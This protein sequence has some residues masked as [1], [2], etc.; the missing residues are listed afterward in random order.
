MWKMSEQLEG[1]SLYSPA[2]TDAPIFLGAVLANERKDGGAE[3]F[4]MKGDVE[5][6]NVD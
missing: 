6:R 2:W 4:M 5:W 1:Q 3:G